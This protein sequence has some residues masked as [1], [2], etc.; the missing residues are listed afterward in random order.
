M[1]VAV[2]T[3]S[4]SFAGT[5]CPA[6]RGVG[7]GFAPT[8]GGAADWDFVLVGAVGVG[9]AVGAA[10]PGGGWA[11]EEYGSTTESNPA[12]IRMKPRQFDRIDKTPPSERLPP[13]GR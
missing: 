3:R 8:G 7:E 4:G 2:T 13:A 6:E 11:R 12:N 9:D 10:V 5:V 1:R